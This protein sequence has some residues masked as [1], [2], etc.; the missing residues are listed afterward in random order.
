[1]GGGSRV[2]DVFGSVSPDV[3]KLDVLSSVCCAGK[4]GHR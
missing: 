1:M 2:L 3:C 4:G